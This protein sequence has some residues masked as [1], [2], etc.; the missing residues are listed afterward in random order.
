MILDLTHIEFFKKIARTQYAVAILNDY[1]QDKNEQLILLANSITNIY[2]YLNQTAFN[3]V[4]I[5]VALDARNHLSRLYNA[6]FVALQS[7]EHIAPVNANEIII[8]VKENGEVHYVLN[9]TP[10]FET[11]RQ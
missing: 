6:S 4:T 7:Y 11:L 8:E 9:T 2:R 1:G 10:D 3:S 5:F